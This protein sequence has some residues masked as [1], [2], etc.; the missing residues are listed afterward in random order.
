MEQNQDSSLF[1][2]NV[3]QVGRS[4]LGE[5][6]RWAKFLAIMGFIFCGLIVLMGVFFGSFMGILS[7]R[8]GGNPYGD[9]VSTPGIGAAM[10]IYYV[11]V[12]LIY[13]FPCLFLYRFATKMRNALAANDQETINTS[14]QNLKATFR[15]M[16]I[17]TIIM[18]AF[19][20]LAFIVALLGVAAGS[21]M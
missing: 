6:A 12:A 5:A 14:F 10:A 4:H 1:G 15:Y 8:S 7:S 19:V 2:I 17:V 20:V 9:V 3:D 13:F 21:N 11:I 18:L 16:G